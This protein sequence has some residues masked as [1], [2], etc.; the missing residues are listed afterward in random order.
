MAQNGP[1]LNSFTIIEEIIDVSLRDFWRDCF[2]DV[3]TQLSKL[4]SSQLSII[5]T[6]YHP[7]LG[8]PNFFFP[9]RHNK[10]QKENILETLF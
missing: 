4:Q 2:S 5:E 7:Y 3:Q 10:N 9:K 8:Y 1:F 6:S